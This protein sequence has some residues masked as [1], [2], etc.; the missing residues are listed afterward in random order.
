MG[1][2]PF[3]ELVDFGQDIFGAVGDVADFALDVVDFAYD[4]IGDLWEFTF[5]L[6]EDG[7]SWVNEEIFEPVISWG[8]EEVVKPVGDFAEG[9]VKGFTEDPVEALIKL[10]MVLSGNAWMIPLLEGQKTYEQGGDWKDI[11][12]TV[13]TGYVTQGV[14]A[15][16]GDFVG[17]YAGEFAGEY[18]GE[19]V[20]NYVSTA[21]GE[22]TSAAALALIYD[23][24]PWEA[25]RRGAVGAATSAAVGQIANRTG[26]TDRFGTAATNKDTG[27]I[28]VDAD[29]NP[30]VQLE[31]L[32]AIVQN[33]IGASISSALYKDQTLSSDQVNNIIAKGIVTSELVMGS[34]DKLGIGIEDEL[35]LE[36]I[37]TTAQRTAGLIL[38]KGLNEETGAIT[39]QYVESALDAYGVEK[40]AEENEEFIKN[41][42]SVVGNKIKDAFTKTAEA[43]E[44]FDTTRETWEE[45]TA[46]LK[47]DVYYNNAQMFGVLNDPENAEDLQ[48]VLTRYAK[49]VEGTA[50]DGAGYIEGTDPFTG[51]RTLTLDVEG[52][53]ERDAAFVESIR[54]EY[55]VIAAIWSSPDNTQGLRATVAK[56]T[57]DKTEGTADYYLGDDGEKYSSRAE[58]EAVNGEGN[59]FV[60]AGPTDKLSIQLNDAAKFSDLVNNPA[61]IQELGYVD[62]DDFL[63]KI[64]TPLPPEDFTSMSQYRAWQNGTKDNGEVRDI[65]ARQVS[66][67][68]MPFQLSPNES[69]FLP[70]KE[71]V[72]GEYINI[73]DPRNSPKPAD[74][75]EAQY[76]ADIQQYIDYYSFSGIK[77]TSMWP[78]RPGFPSNLNRYLGFGGNFAVSASLRFYEPTVYDIR[79]AET[80]VVSE[81]SGADYTGQGQFDS[82]VG[83]PVDVVQD[84]Q[85][86]QWVTYYGTG[87]SGP[88]YSSYPINQYSSQVDRTEQRDRRLDGDSTS[89]QD[90]L[91][92]V[93]RLQDEGIPDL[94][95]TQAETIN[96]YYADYFT[97]LDEFDTEVNLARDANEISAVN[98]ILGF[99]VSLNEYRE[100]NNLDGRISVTD[101][102]FNNAVNGNSFF[103]QEEATLQRTEAISAVLGES[104]YDQFDISPDE[105]NAVIEAKYGDGGM[106]AEDV[107]NIFTD[108][109]YRQ[110]LVNEVNY[111]IVYDNYVNQGIIER[112][113]ALPIIINDGDDLSRIY[114]EAERIVADRR[115]GQL[116]N[117]LLPYYGEGVTAANVANG[118]A[119]V[120]RDE[121]QNLYYGLT[122]INTSG[123]E[124]GGSYITYSPEFGAV[125]TI[126]SINEDGNLVQVTT[127]TDGNPLAPPKIIDVV[128]TAYRSVADQFIGEQIGDGNFETAKKYALNNEY[129]DLEYEFIE[130]LETWLTGEDSTLGTT[131]RWGDSEVLWGNA[132]RA[133]GGIL[134]SINGIVQIA[135]VAP[136]STLLYDFAN[137]LI[138][139]GKE[140]NPEEYTKE[141]AE[142]YKELSKPLDWSDRPPSLGE[143]SAVEV[144]MAKTAQVFGA[145]SDNPT[146]FLVDAVGVEFAQEAL[147]L[148]IGGF[149]KLGASLVGWTYANAVRL[150]VS[151]SV[152]TDIAESVGSN[153]TEGFERAFDYKM[154]DLI[155]NEGLTEEQAYDRAEAYAMDVGLTNG[156][157]AGGV[158]VV[159]LGLDLPFDKLLL[160]KQSPAFADYAGELFNSRVVKAGTEGAQVLG[161]QFLNEFAEGSLPAVY[162]AD[163]FSQYDPTISRTEDGILAGWMEG[164]VGTTVST[165]FYTGAKGLQAVERVSNGVNELVFEVVRDTGDLVSNIFMQ[166]D[167]ATQRYLDAYTAQYQDMFDTAWR[168]AYAEVNDPNIDVTDFRNNFQLEFDSTEYTDGLKN[169]L[170]VLG[171]D[172]TYTQSNVLSVID[173]N[174]LSTKDI[175]QVFDETGYVPT[176]EDI[177]SFVG[178]DETVNDPDGPDLSTR[179]LEYIDPLY[180]SPE[181]VLQAYK[182]AGLEAPRQGDID[183]F[184]GNV[185][186]VD[187]GG[188]GLGT[189]IVEYLPTA[190]ANSTAGIIVD[191]FGNKFNELGFKVDDFGVRIDDQ[192]N[193]LDEF[194]YAIDEF[195]VRLIDLSS[196]INEQG[197]RVNEQGQKVDEF[198]NRIDD[199][200]NRIDEQGNVLSGFGTALDEQGLAINDLGTRIDDQGN[201]VD[202]LGN[203]IDVQGA[204]I[205]EFGNK[206]DAQGI[207]IADIGTELDAQGNRIDE[208]GNK[209]DES[210]DTLND[211]IIDTA[212]DVTTQITT[213]IATRQQN[214]ALRQAVQAGMRQGQVSVSSAPAKELEYIYDFN[215]IFATPEQESLF[216]VNPFSSSEGGARQAL[217]PEDSI[218]GGMA[219]PL[220]FAAKRGGLVPSSTDKLLNILGK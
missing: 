141:A 162:L 17:D 165:G 124:G 175:T 197:E 151:A 50:V 2:D 83:Y 173:D 105:L 159:T 85:S 72:N 11:L 215:S 31:G 126:Q 167:A 216:A 137:K 161:G 157:L 163:E 57:G 1:W 158:T 168:A 96:G 219:Q 152:A 118:E 181:E 154:K 177:T 196:T 139:L 16:I 205:D 65:P 90:D 45:A 60:V 195:G 55:P 7:L 61:L 144:A 110:D 93:T 20:G 98:D 89:Y 36:Y 19:N 30:R 114:D 54:E 188:V 43:G 136:P 134:K 178:F 9:F 47:N 112:G 199:L 184:V 203:R 71:F 125:L 3:G 91:D 117:D 182:D 10:G 68:L 123:I 115:V 74:L 69:K 41:T 44:E 128:L 176:Q 145:I 171:I 42:L 143:P 193:R 207:A 120:F 156:M 206:L 169:R 32:P 73:A 35:A 111:K 8:Y 66:N 109:V 97:A 88:T 80:V 33:L 76:Q 53:L 174:Y 218:F 186:I 81:P 95:Q 217:N 116:N 119:R 52:A 220:R 185:S 12:K 211:T 113:D 198:G 149:A 56:L 103:T 78:S 58:V 62:T 212:T 86:T 94:I 23:E 48:D 25:F 172:D 24:D 79:P 108:S 131:S 59:Y 146:M 147:P 194:G 155:A 210:V 192:G 106:S 100:A 200:G 191:E 13:G 26:L 51:E 170:E 183:R 201:L 148:A 179:I 5:D 166:F 75:T 208:F 140:I 18:V 6:A 101:D 142:F 153:A 84:R 4:S 22:G 64:T 213:D 27:E 29:G 102:I 187:A 129:S 40:F 164:L 202:D 67:T 204:R 99:T 180:Y 82:L 190:E 135:G 70:P 127:D 63:S 38:Y 133:G 160:G 28:L 14:G 130:S 39:A 46:R 150:G 214:N 132:L 104:G 209:L 92:L 37:T 121:N 107:N 15:Y 77:N 122:G 87:I 189:Q 21:I 138:D 49:V 34:L